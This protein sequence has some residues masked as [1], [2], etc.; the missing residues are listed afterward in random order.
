M[1]L[2]AAFGFLSKYLFIYLLVSIDL[3]FIYLIF[4]KKD[5]KFDFKYLI[6][7]LVVVD[8]ENRPIG[9]IQIY[10]ILRAGVY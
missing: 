4:F 1:G 9:I 2:F 7:C 3:L 8:P 10:Y 5:R 6:T